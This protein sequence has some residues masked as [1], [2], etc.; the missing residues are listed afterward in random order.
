L[1]AL[2]RKYP[3][4]IFDE[5]LRNLPVENENDPKAIDVYV[6]K[7]SGT[8]PHP[9]FPTIDVDWQGWQ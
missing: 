5:V 7:K 8:F 3:V 1:L 4:Q 6:A 2:R 9:A